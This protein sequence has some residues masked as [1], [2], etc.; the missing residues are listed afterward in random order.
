LAGFGPGEIRVK[1][2]FQPDA[3]NEATSRM[4]KLPPTTNPQWSKMD[5]AEMMAH[6]YATLAWA[7]G[8]YKPLDLCLRQFGVGSR[9]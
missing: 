2:L 4:D 1:N 8:I 9:I 6:C 5:V 3:V 7:T